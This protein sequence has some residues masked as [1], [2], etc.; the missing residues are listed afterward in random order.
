MRWKDIK[1]GKKMGIG[2]GI[3]LVLLAFVTTW[4]IFGINDIVG[5]AGQVIDGNKLD[6]ILAQREVD[7]LNWAGSVNTLLTDDTVTHLNV[8]T[9][10]HRCGLG[11]WLYGEGRKSAE[12]LVPSLAPLLKNIEE[13]H[14]H[15][16]ESAITIGEQFKQADPLLP[17]VLLARQIDHLNWATAIRNAFLEHKDVLGVETDPDQC[18]LGKWMNSEDGKKAYSHGSPEFKE[19]WLKMS[20]NHKDLHHSAIDIGKALKESEQSAQALFKTETVPL[21]ENT[22]GNLSAMLAIAEGDLKG[23][24]EA[25]ETYAHT[26]MPALHEVQ[27][28]IEEIRSEAKANIMTD[29]QMLNAAVSTRTGVIIFSIIAVLAGIA[30]AVVIAKGIVTPIIKGVR[31]AET[32]AKGDLTATMDIRQRDEVGMMADAMQNMVEKLS[33][34]VSEVKAAADNVADGSQAL[35]ATAEEM[36]QG[37][38]EQAAAA[39]EASSSMEQM[40]ANIKQ[41]ADNASQ[42]EMI[43]TKSSGSAGESGDAVGQTVTAMRNIAEKISIIEEIARQTDLLALNAAIEAARAGEHGKGFAVVASEVRKLA[44]RSQV[45]AGEISRLSSSS[46]DIAEK[47][48]NMLTQL[49][50]DIQQTAELVKEISAAS[51][52]QNS[53]AEQINKAIQQLD[54]VIQ[55]N[56]SASEEM[57]STSEELTGQAE[58][59]QQTI[60]FFKIDDKGNGRRKAGSIR[61]ASPHHPPARTMATA[62]AQMGHSIGGNGHRRNNETAPHGVIIDMGDDGNGTGHDINPD[63]EFER[64]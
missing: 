7:H 46:V 22:L 34:I 52:E 49:V 37:A 15:L 27:G 60:S 5:N 44:E 33:E 6:G 24:Q 47:A 21:L 61:K 40:A 26:T 55:Q 53:G 2:Y 11:Q 14:R 51:T 45:A 50:P 38:T 3:V 48:G 12:K 25:N 17:P 28:I 31:F 56:A 20:K 58:Q 19:A 8:E 13:P 43:A 23:M 1:L 41:N 63:E 18:A 62:S 4:A 36:S 32:V 54:E 29:E 42:T 39:E 64:F 35:S 30:L 59:L 16:H 9:D 57:S 10:D